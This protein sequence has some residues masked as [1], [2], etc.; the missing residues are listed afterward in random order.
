M[1]SSDADHEYRE[2]HEGM[3]IDLSDKSTVDQIGS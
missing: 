3:R 2:E 1:K